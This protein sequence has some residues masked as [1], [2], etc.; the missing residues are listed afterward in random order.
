MKSKNSVLIIEDSPAVGMLLAEFMKKLG[1]T[2]IKTAESGHAGISLFKQFVEKDITPLIFLDYNLPDSTAN[3]IMSQIL[4]IKPFTKIIIETANSKDE[5]T[6]KEVIGLGAYHYLQKPIHFN[7]VEKIITILE[8]EESYLEKK[9]P[10]TSTSQED[11]ID[12]EKIIEHIDFI[13]KTNN[14]ISLNKIEQIL[15]FS[16][17]FIV[18]Y[19]KKLETKGKIVQLDNKKEIA[20]NQCDSIRTSQ[21]FFCPT[22]K[23][24]NFKL[25]KLIEHYDCG[26]ITEES[27]YENELC[28]NCKKEIK[29]L[30]VDY[31]VMQNHYI[32]NDCG[33]LSPEI[34]TSYICLKCESRFKLEEAR[35]KSSVNYKVLNTK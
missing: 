12:E 17:E 8:E 19:L 27:T 1:Y 14:Q 28:P 6:I 23:S 11:D 4:P 13:L 21:V 9:S 2:D 18:T 33:G 35:W 3:S 10:R 20:C 34:S 15:G 30:G 31:R 7:E 29:A 32:C 5:D 26:N 22:C 16:N 25:G 24:S